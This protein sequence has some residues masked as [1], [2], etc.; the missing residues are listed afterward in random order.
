MLLGWMVKRQGLA[1]LGEVWM[2]E[3]AATG[4][5][6]F[7]PLVTSKGREQ[8][9]SRVVLGE[10]AGPSKGVMPLQVGGPGPLPFPF[11]SW[12]RAP[13]RMHCLSSG[14]KETGSTRLD[15]SFPN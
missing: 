12:P 6:R 10:V 15:P 3:P 7:G 2:R 9:W 14:P 4:V 13:L 5:P 8:A 1:L 11:A